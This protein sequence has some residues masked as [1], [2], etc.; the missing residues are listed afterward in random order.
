MKLH[1][2]F[3]LA[4]AVFT[5]WLVAATPAQAEGLFTPF[6]GVTVGGSGSNGRGL[7]GASLG[8]MNAGIF[9]IEADVAHSPNFF[10]TGSTVGVGDSSVT[11][12]MVSL[13]LGVPVGGTSGIGVRPYGL[14]GAG[15][16]RTSID[17]ASE[18]FDDIS[19]NDVGVNLGAG[20]L[21]FLNDHVGLKGE[22]RYFRSLQD[23]DD[24]PVG[25]SLSDFNFTR[26]TGGIS[27]R[28]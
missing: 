28:F 6:G 12:A 4:S 7:F 21:V 14:A 24:E 22:V 17:S 18:F 23:D 27:I 9:G 20:V 3:L 11:T 8:Y 2:G 5:S 16:I 25:V 1:P 10:G 15:L 13:L 19:R 26:V